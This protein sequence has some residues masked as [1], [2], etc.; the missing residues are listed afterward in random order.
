MTIAL[1]DASLPYCESLRKIWF[2][3]RP[4]WELS[5]LMMRQSLSSANQGFCCW[6]MNLQKTSRD[7]NPQ[8]GCHY[9]KNYSFPTTD[10]YSTEIL[11]TSFK[12]LQFSHYWLLNWDFIYLKKI[13]SFSTVA[14]LR[15]NWIETIPTVRFPHHH[16]ELCFGILSRHCHVILN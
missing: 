5:K 10:D 15:L 12:Y 2:M 14:D 1:I 11:F 4:G 8:L 16:Q 9:L 7:T 13:S 3:A 6:L